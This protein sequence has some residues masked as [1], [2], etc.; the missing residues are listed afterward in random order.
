MRPTAYQSSSIHLAELS[1]HSLPNY[2]IRNP[3]AVEP[4]LQDP[5]AGEEYVIVDV[6]ALEPPLA[7]GGVKGASGMQHPPIVKDHTLAL[8]QPILEQALLGTEQPLEG[9]GGSEIVS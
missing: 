5:Q 3:G 4:F 1:P 2:P 6:R 8:V 7:F 9:M